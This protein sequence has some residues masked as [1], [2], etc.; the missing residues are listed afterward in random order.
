MGITHLRQQ[1]RKPEIISLVMADY[2]F[3]CIFPSERI[4]RSHSQM[5]YSELNRDRTQLKLISAGV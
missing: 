5:V 2:F 4:I 3:L 1:R